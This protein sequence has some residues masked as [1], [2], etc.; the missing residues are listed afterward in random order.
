MIAGKKRRVGG[1]FA[2]P[3]VK[4]PAK[5]GGGGRGGKSRDKKRLTLGV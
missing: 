2:G 5:K 4:A 3:I 1:G